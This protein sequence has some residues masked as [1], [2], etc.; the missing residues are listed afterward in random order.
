DQSHWQNRAIMATTPGSVFKIVVAVAALEEGLCTPGTMFECHGSWDKYHLHDAKLE[1]HGRVTLTQAFANSC[2]VVFAQLASKLGGAKLE[3]YARRLGLGGMVT[4]SGNIQSC[5]KLQQIGEEEA[6][7]IFFAS[8]LQS[9]EGAVAQSGIG[10]RDVQVSLL[11]VVNM[12]T[13]LFHE[14][15]PLSPRVASSVLD[16]N[17]DVYAV[18]PMQYL[19]S[20]APL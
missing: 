8:N 17:G 12:V 11:Q 10:Q 3:A 7:R 19:P 1:G 18:F 6:G 20:R 9:D 5:G 16:E 4:W 15:C 2:N 13:A 14:G